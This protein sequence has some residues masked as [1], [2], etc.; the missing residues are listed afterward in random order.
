MSGNRQVS[1]TD[2]ELKALVE[3]L[4][5]ALEVCPVE[6]IGYDMTIT[7]DEIQDLIQRFEKTL[8]S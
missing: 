5:Y 3:I 2:D 6:G 4:R 7:R 1:F 8:R